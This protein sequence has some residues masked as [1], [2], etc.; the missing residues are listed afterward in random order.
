[1]IHSISTTTQNEKLAHIQRVWNSLLAPHVDLWS[2]LDQL[3]ANETDEFGLQYGFFSRIDLDTETQRFEVV[4][5]PS[6]NLQEKTD[7]PLETTYCRKTI[8]DPAGTMVVNDA[9]AEGWAG[10]PAYETFGFGS[11]VGTTVNA[12]GE[13]YG[14]LCFA[15]ADPRDEPLTR[16]E[17][18]LV[19]MYG[20]WVTY[21][22]NQWA[23]PPTHDTGDTADEY[24]MSPSQIDGIMDILSNHVRRCVLI[25]FL[26]GISEADIETLRQLSHVEN[27]E[28]LLYHVHLPKLAHA[29]YIE[30]D[31]DSNVVARGPR[32]REIEPLLDLL[33]E[34]S[35]ECFG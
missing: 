32:F 28:K 9:L 22:L 26:E 3:F 5:G 24:S 34:H 33:K 20:Q 21:E 17:V 25:A 23:G 19:E 4:H 18:I 30:W 12:E 8:A 16:E 29:G 13:L 1:M 31:R 6:D 7:V 27:N 15:R 11:Y 14:T 35:T 2:K 10:D